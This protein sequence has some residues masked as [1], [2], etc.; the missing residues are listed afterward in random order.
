MFKKV[1]SARPQAL[2]R[3]ERTGEYVRAENAA[4]LSAVALAKADDLFHHS[5]AENTGYVRSFV[6]EDIHALFF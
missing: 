2:W 3:V 5:Q 1:R 6:V 4:G